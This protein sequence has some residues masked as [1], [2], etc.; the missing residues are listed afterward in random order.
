MRTKP[1]LAYVGHAYHNKTRSTEFFREILR[2][3]FDVTEYAI[4]PWKG[5]R[6][7]PVDTLNHYEYVL[8]FQ[9]VSPVDDLRKLTGKVAWVQMYDSANFDYF[10]WK[11]LS[12]LSIKVIA[13]SEKIQQQCEKFGIECLKVRYYLN[14]AEY[15]LPDPASGRHVFFW[16]RGSVQ[17]KTV[18][19]ILDPNQVDSFA[20]LSNP[21]PG[22]RREDIPPEDV[23]NYKMEIMERDFANSREE[24]LRQLSKANIV[25]APRLKE[26]I[27]LS[28]I[29]ALA[30]GR[31][32]IGNDE[33]TMNEY[34]E[35][36]KTGYLF[37]NNAPE[38]LDLSG[39]EKIAENSRKAAQSGYTTW[40][41]DSKKIIPFLKTAYIP[42][43]KGA[44]ARKVYEILYSVKLAA[45]PWKEKIISKKLT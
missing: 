20:Y 30:A 37:K 44:V 23:K 27:G 40:F 31:A 33:G 2:Q 43:Q 24:Y 45:H 29:E 11:N 8:F 16:Y 4:N 9:R 32:V 36:G 1:R 15:V 10:F 34:I 39:F 18:R 42:S 14:P 6:T 7:I 28:F 17:W 3:E 12:F 35:N 21:D 26:G 5:D 38:K 41:A 25:I 19:G 22:Y 13:F